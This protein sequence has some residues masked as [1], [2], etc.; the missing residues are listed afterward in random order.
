MS[1]A[2]RLIMKEKSTRFLTKMK[3]LLLE[4][5]ALKLL[6]L[7]LW[8]KI[9][10]RHLKLLLLLKKKKSCPKLFRKLERWRIRR[11]LK[12]IPRVKSLSI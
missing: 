9:L 3:S 5:L 7:L 10:N 12:L 6:T 2:S 1:K 8:K 4:L 11:N